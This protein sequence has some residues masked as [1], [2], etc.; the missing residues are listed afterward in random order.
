MWTDQQQ[1]QP[2]PTPAAMT[3]A[4][5][6]QTLQEYVQA[7]KNAVAAGFDGVEVHAANGYLLEQFIRPNSNVRTDQYGGSIEGRARFV[8]EVVDGIVE[9]IGREKVGIRFSPSSVF[10]DMTLY[11]QID[12]EYTYIAK[13]INER[14]L[15]YIHLVDHSSLGATPPS[16]AIRTVLRNQSNCALILS[17]GYDFKRA[18]ADLVAGK[19]DLIAVGRPILANPDLKKRWETGAPLNQ[20][21]MATFYTPGPK[22]YTDYP[23]LG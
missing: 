23:T 19:A 2:L 17:G 22:G 11:P 1:M 7:A 9:A 15:L 12:A 20:A 8:L 21:D 6:Q 3:E 5:L 16:E 14:G 4:E 10:N 13:Q 18:E